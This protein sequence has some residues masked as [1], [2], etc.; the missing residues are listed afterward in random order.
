VEVYTTQDICKLLKVSENHVRK[1]I[2]RG[3][4]KAW[5]EGRKGGYRVREESLKEYMKVKEDDMDTEVKGVD[6]QEEFDFED[7]TY[8]D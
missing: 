2:K 7:L 6:L 3:K 1:L 8:E 5:R 4:L